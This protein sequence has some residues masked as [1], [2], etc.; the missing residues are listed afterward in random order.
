[1]SAYMAKLASAKA[2]PPGL[3]PPKRPFS[4]PSDKIG[5]DAPGMQT[6]ITTAAPPVGLGSE[7]LSSRTGDIRS[8]R[9]YIG[10][11]ELSSN[12]EPVIASS[13]VAQG[14]S[15]TSQPQPRKAGHSNAGPLMTEVATSAPTSRGAEP[16]RPAPIQRLT[17]SP[18]SLERNVIGPTSV[19]EQQPTRFIPSDR[20][21]SETDH[22][23]LL[24]EGKESHEAASSWKWASGQPIQPAQSARSAAAYVP[25]HPMAHAERDHEESEGLS[26]SRQRLELSENA[27][28]AMTLPMGPERR[29]LGASKKQV[30]MLTIGTLEITVVPPPAPTPAPTPPRPPVVTVIGPAHSQPHQPAL[31]WYGI[32]QT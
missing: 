1:M 2:P 6:T 21:P 29:A 12:L 17:S 25:D 30:P 7:G 14:L 10:H 18:R 5:I 22:S 28:P 23:T 8:A 13:P 16:T 20:T 19:V 24:P 4:H 11:A 26:A 27:A 32:A 9:T 15:A 3:K 31:A